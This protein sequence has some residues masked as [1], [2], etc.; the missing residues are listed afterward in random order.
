MSEGEVDIELEIDEEFKL[1]IDVLNN[2]DLE[3]SEKYVYIKDRYNKL[4]ERYKEL[5]ILYS[6]NTVIQSMNDMRDRFEQ[7]QRETVSLYRYNELDK[8]YKKQNKSINAIHVILENTCKRLR[9]TIRET[10]KSTTFDSTYD[11]SN[12]YKCEMELM[13]INELLEKHIN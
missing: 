13:I 2:Y 1:D 3:S 9:D 4:L 10:S 8:K 11:N 12:L 7:L 6:E 5:C